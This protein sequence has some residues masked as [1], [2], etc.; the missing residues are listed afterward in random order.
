LDVERGRVA[1]LRRRRATAGAVE[2]ERLAG[3]TTVAI[4]AIVAE[5]DE[6]RDGRRRPQDKAAE[7]EVVVGERAD[8]RARVRAADLEPLEP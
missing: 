2:V 6:R 1:G 8:I 3:R 5:L 7:A 4:I